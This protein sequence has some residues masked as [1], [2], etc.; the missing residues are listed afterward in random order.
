MERERI[1]RWENPQAS[2]EKAR[3]MNGLD[4]L[5]KIIEGEIPP[6]PTAQLLGMKLV[7]AEAGTATFKMTVGEFQYNPLGVVHGGIIT[8]LLDSAMGCAIQTNLPNG[9]T[10]TTT[11]LSIN[12]VRPL[13]IET[14]MVTCI[15]QV[16]HVGRRLATA[17]AQ[18]LDEQQKLY[19]HGTSTCMV[20][21]PD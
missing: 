4:F 2:A 18:V 5:R 19:A 10:Y 14:R 17:S 13:T 7:Q 8:T 6:P 3:Q 11:Q 15:A 16:I 12:L 20:F 9:T 1:V 21:Q